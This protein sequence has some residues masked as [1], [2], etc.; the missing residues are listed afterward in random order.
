MPTTLL[1]PF[2]FV[3]FYNHALVKSTKPLAFRVYYNHTP[4]LL[5]PYITLDVA[6]YKSYY[7]H[8]PVVSKPITVALLLV[9][10]LRSSLLLEDL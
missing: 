10:L 3:E 5:Q 2:A 1:Q 9:S 8:T 4:T 7:S 6:I